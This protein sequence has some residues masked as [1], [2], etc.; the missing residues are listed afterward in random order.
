MG[1]EDDVVL[2]GV[3]E[4]LLQVTLVLIASALRVREV[5]RGERRQEGT[6]VVIVIAMAKRTDR[7]WVLG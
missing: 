2:G 1:C 7:V 3:T 6:T 4:E 5:K